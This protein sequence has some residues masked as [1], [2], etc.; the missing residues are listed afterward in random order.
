MISVS[1]VSPAKNPRGRR[2][3]SPVGTT[4]AKTRLRYWGYLI[5]GAQTRFYAPER[6]F[7]QNNLSTATTISH[8]HCFAPR[9]QPAPRPITWRIYKKKISNA[10]AADPQPIYI[11]TADVLARGHSKRSNRE[12]STWAA[13]SHN[14]DIWPYSS[15]ATRPARDC[16]T[17][18]SRVVRGG[19][20]NCNS[21]CKLHAAENTAISPPTDGFF[22][23]C[24]N[25]S[26]GD[27]RS[28]TAYKLAKWTFR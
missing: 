1:T 9:P 18:N 7:E 20:I 26:A 14:Y 28:P 22:A 6:T 21:R 8:F 15:S 3:S 10:E 2:L 24:A 19:R 13:T 23:R 5:E 11:R 4:R 16:P 12:S 25:E 27:L 17:R